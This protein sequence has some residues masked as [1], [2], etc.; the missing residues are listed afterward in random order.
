M[1]S[2]TAHGNILQVDRLAVS[3]SKA[4]TISGI[5]R[6][7]LYEALTSGELPSLKVGTRRLIRIAALEAWLAAREA[8]NR[9]PQKELARKPDHG[10][11]RVSGS[12]R[13]AAG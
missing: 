5:G 8:G 9:S 10:S 6:T 2:H 13:S 12:K 7:K 3:P 1:F 4:A 11:R